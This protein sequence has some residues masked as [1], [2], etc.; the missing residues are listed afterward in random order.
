MNLALWIVTGLL[1]AVFLL[2]GATKLFIPREK[3]ARAPGGGWVEDF[4][5]GFVKAL[6]A[7]EVLGAVGLVLPAVLGIAPVLVPLAA[8]GLM[9]V[10]AGAAVVTFRREE[11]LH[12]VLNL[13]YLA[14]AAFVAWGRFGPESFVG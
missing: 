12:A 7:V 13:A 9:V 2:A 1:A 11:P 14:L 4:G 10:M 5:A 8:V 3:L 6:G